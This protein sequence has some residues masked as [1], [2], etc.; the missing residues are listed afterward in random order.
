MKQK[1]FALFSA[2][3]LLM[4]SACASGKAEIGTEQPQSAG[5][6]ETVPSDSSEV[7]TDPAETAQLV[8]FDS[9]LGCSTTYDP[10][11]FT[12]KDYEDEYYKRITQ[13][14]VESDWENDGFTLNVRVTPLDASS[15]EEAVDEVVS[16]RAVDKTYVVELRDEVEVIRE[17]VT[18]GSGRYPAVRLTYYEQ[19]AVGEIY[20]TEQ[21]G[22][23]YE[24]D[25][26]SYYQPPEELLTQAYAILDSITF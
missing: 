2:L 7:Q 13:F 3:V 11:V 17:E 22:T 6:P 4:L 5:V 26:S 1:I 20:V 24:V 25:V 21:N 18:F 16:S 19:Y 23:V 14:I 8:R 10:A 12:A 15:V 9:K